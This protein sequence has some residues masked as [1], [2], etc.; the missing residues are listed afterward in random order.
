MIGVTKVLEF[1]LCSYCFIHV[2]EAGIN[3]IY[4]IG[5]Y[6]NIWG[7]EFQVGAQVRH[8]EAWFPSMKRLLEVV[9]YVTT[10]KVETDK[11]READVSVYVK[12]RSFG[13]IYFFFFNLKTKCL[14]YRMGYG[15]LVKERPPVL[16]KI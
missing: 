3:H 4:E 9:A 10:S 11:S 1:V 12:V 16:W 6:L 7:I 14:K 15:I 13:F 2:L 5:G 8:V